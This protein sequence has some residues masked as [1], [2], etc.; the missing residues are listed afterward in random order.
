MMFDAESGLFLDRALS[1]G[2]ERADF[3][4]RHIT[5]SYSGHFTPL[6]FWLETLQARLYGPR[7]PLWFWRQMAALAFL[8]TAILL[9]LRALFGG[10]TAGATWT[11]AV[12]GAIFF[13]CHPDI[14]QLVAWPFMVLQLLC[15]AVTALAAHRWVRVTQS[16][17]SEDLWT[18]LLVS[19]ASMHLLGVGLAVSLAAM[20]TTGVW[21]LLRWLDGDAS[22]PWLRSALLAL[23]VTGVLTAFHGAAMASGA[24]VPGSAHLRFAIHLRRLGFFFVRSLYAGA[25]ALWSNGGMPW[26]SV[27]GERT[28]A[29]YGW[30]LLVLSI[31]GVILLGRRFH[32][33]R[34]P[35]DGAVFGLALF[36]LTAL[37]AD[38][39]LILIRLRHDGSAEAQANYL[40]GARYLLFPSLFL[41]LGGTALFAGRVSR[42]GPAAVAASVGFAVTAAIATSTFMHTLMPIVFPSMTVDATE[43]WAEIVSTA[44]SELATAGR[45]HDRSLEELDPEF[46]SS[47]RERPLLLERSLGCHGCTQF[48]GR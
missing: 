23:L 13:L 45:I 19:Y 43:R 20:S 8:G 17:R 35:R 47:L 16:N 3:M 6:A 30:G 24:K 11:F 42:L 25:E 40:I 39:V 46:K 29:V 9:Y 18:F 10:G 7:E 22:K 15:A 48:T 12:A 5:G 41:F 31:F 36:S 26:P 28:D 27:R 33:S 34:H 4:H 32:R 2:A 1:S 14:V 37:V 44:R 38:L 21:V